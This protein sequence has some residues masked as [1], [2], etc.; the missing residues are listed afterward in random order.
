MAAALTYA[1]LIAD[2]Q[3]YAERGDAAFIAQLPRFVMY[4][5]TRIASEAKGLGFIN[6]VTANLIVGQNGSALAKPA[7]WRE[8][9]ALII[10]TGTPPNLTTQP[11]NSRQRLKLR[12]YEYCRA[13]W[14]DPTQTDVPIYYAD[15]TWQ[16]LLIVPSPSQAFPYELLYF[17]RPVA[18]DAN[19]Q[20]NWTTQFAPQL[21]LYACM[22]E[23]AA[24]VK[25]KSRLAEWQAGFDRCLK[26][27][28]FES[29]RR[30]NDRTQA[31]P[32]PE[33]QGAR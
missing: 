25:N 8:N 22:L 33:A 29:Q 3:A 32:K 14:P 19:N 12:S 30:V 2:I 31:N 20:V 4:A 11:F 5:E 28:E 10:G 6:S 13:Y 18:L 7:D 17:Q 16:Q 27:V 23:A 21:L 24:W 26:Q 15:W 9:V 1:T